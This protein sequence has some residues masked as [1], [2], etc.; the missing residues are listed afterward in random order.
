MV[1][2]KLTPVGWMMLA[3]GVGSDQPAKPLPVN[4]M[5]L[6][7]NAMDHSQKTKQGITIARSNGVHWGSHGAILAKHNKDAAQAFAETLRPLI[8]ELMAH[9]CNGAA[10]L[11]RAMNQRGVMSRNGGNWHPGS[12]QRVIDR[13]R[14]SLDE[15]I[16]LKRE[17]NFKKATG[18]LMATEV[19]ALKCNKPEG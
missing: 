11:A 7:A 17:E 16:S 2:P 8:V 9:K 18:A 14:P 13:L 4:E 3:K 12:A 19:L 10:S 6:T 1:E 15:D 5:H